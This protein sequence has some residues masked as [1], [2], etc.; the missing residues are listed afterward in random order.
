[1]S[2]GNNSVDTIDTSTGTPAGMCIVVVVK[3]EIGVV[4]LMCFV[5]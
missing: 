1:M 4:V 5:G 2:I 3:L